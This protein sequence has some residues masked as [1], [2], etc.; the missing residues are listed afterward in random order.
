M[1]SAF[2]VATV[3]RVATLGC[4]FVALKLL[5]PLGCVAETD[6]GVTMNFLTLGIEKQRPVAFVDKDS[7]GL[8]QRLG[9]LGLA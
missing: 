5:V 4:F 6:V 8:D 7:I 9:L 2:G 3:D 1:I